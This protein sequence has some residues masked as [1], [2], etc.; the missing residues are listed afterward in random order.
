MQIR[1]QMAKNY[2]KYARAKI[3]GNMDTKNKI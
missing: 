3:F 1:R 2:D